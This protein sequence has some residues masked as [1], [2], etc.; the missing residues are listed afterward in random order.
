MI[1]VKGFLRRA[2]ET[3]EAGRVDEPIADRL[4]LLASRG[5]AL[6]LALRS[7]PGHEVTGAV[8][9]PTQDR[10]KAVSDWLAMGAALLA[11]TGPFENGF[12]RVCGCTET[13]ACGV[14]ID[15]TFS[16]ACG[17]VSGTKFEESDNARTLCDAPACV[18]AARSAGALRP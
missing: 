1:G 11:T 6:E 3:I 10:T 7:D 16:R 13:T 12:C 5:Y 15:E 18:E 9:E 14:P 4:L 8:V 2:G 17:W